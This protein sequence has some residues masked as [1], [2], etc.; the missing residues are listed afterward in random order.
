MRIID[1]RGRSRLTGEAPPKFRVT[2]QRRR[3]NLQRHQPAQ[4][5]IACPEHDG[6]PALADPLLE[7][8]TRNARACREADYDAVGSSV[9]ITAHHASPAH[10]PDELADTAEPHQGYFVSSPSDLRHL[11]LMVAV[12]TRD[13]NARKGLSTVSEA[14]AGH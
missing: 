13:R 9:I 11:D 6:H 7:P 4:L 14:G 2:R 8:V 12:P 1:R 3:E 5:L 10:G